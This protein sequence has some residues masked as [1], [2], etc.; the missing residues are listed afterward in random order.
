[1]IQRVSQLKERG[2]QK[3]EE[4]RVLIPPLHVVRVGKLERIEL[5]SAEEGRQMT[6]CELVHIIDLKSFVE[7]E[8]RR[9][10][11]GLPEL[12]AGIDEYC[13]EKNRNGA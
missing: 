12:A 11:Q 9:P 8:E 3:V 1:M 13:S 4:G 10:C 6:L 2:L 7:T 5:R